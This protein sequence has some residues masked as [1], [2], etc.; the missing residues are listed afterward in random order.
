MGIGGLRL[1]DDVGKGLGAIAN[2]VL[3]YIA[4]AK[5]VDGLSDLGNYLNNVVVAIA[6]TKH[7][8][9]LDVNNARSKRGYVNGDIF[10][11]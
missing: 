6:N 9:T 3:G 2:A 4:F 1:L 11:L 7:F 8:R 5:A 10:F